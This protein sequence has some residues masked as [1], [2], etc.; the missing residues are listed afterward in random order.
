M[1]LLSATPHQ[2]R[3]DRFKALLQLLRPELSEA[4]ERIDRSPEL[5]ADMVFRNRKE[6]VRNM[7]GSLVFKGKLVS[8]VEVARTD[9]ERAFDRS[10]Q[11]YFKQGYAAAERAAGKRTAIGFVMTMYRKLAASSLGAIR[12]AL[13]RRLQRLAS[14]F[15]A[16]GASTDLLIDD[17]FEGET[18]EIDLG[19]IDGEQ[20]F[21]DGESAMLA[22]LIDE[23]RVLTASDSKLEAFIKLISNELAGHVNEGR[24]VVFTE[25]RATQDLL[26]ARLRAEFGPD[27]AAQ[28]NGGQRFD[29]REDSIREF[30]SSARFL[31]S[32]EAGGEGLN[33]QRRCHVMVN[34]DLPWNPMRLVQRIGRLYRYGQQKPVVV[35]NLAASQTVDERVV[36]VMYERLDQVVADLSDVSED[37]GDGMHTEW[38]GEVV[39]LLDVSNIMEQAIRLGESRTADLIDEAISAAADATARQRELFQHVAGFDPR[40]LDDQLQISAGHLQRY[41]LGMCSVLEIPVERPRALTGVWRLRLDDVARKAIGSERN[42]LLIAFDRTLGAAHADV[43]LVDMESPLLRWLLEQTE[44]LEFGGRCSVIVGMDCKAMMTAMLRWQ[45]DR[46][47]RRREEFAAISINEAGDCQSNP[48]AFS[49]WLMSESN[50][51]SVTDANTDAA[52]WLS[53]AHARCDERLGDRSTAFL[54]PE[55]VELL[56]ACA[57]GA[58][59]ETR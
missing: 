6:S 43:E 58:L 20:E 23:A 1:L 49:D 55:S 38:L 29:E 40:E 24:I 9:R 8:R 7:D 11:R 25:Y 51:G 30:E 56:G 12:I 10:L 3:Q 26:V 22:E 50:D 4:L 2:G 39:E 57:V 45:D 31:V 37:Y 13:E 21:F 52:T 5:L 54:H 16:D 59:R 32:T 44:P 27:A 42:S 18:E 46:G 53:S 35:L 15:R 34:Y 28:I 48:T 36:A 19:R 41:V 33:M 17:R 14:E 47:R